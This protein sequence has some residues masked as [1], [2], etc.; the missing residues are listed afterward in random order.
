MRIVYAIILATAAV[1]F[2]GCK[3]EEAAGVT[4]EENDEDRQGTQ[5]GAN[6]KM[7][8]AG[9]ASMTPEGESRGEKGG[10]VLN[11]ARAL[12]EA[13]NPFRR[14]LLYIGHHDDTESNTQKNGIKR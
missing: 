10:Y 5:L 12:R 4:G 6:N 8:R 9:S 2:E 11:A 7:G 1:S 14:F 13:I 3:V